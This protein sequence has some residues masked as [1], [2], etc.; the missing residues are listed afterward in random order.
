MNIQELREGAIAKV[1]KSFDGISSEEFDRKLDSDYY[2]VRLLSYSTIKKAIVSPE[3]FLVKINEDFKNSGMTIG[4]FMHV[5]MLEPQ[6]IG[7]LFIILDET[8]FPDECY[9]TGAINKMK[10]EEA[11]AEAIAELKAKGAVNNR[12]SVTK[13]F[14][15]K[16]EKRAKDE[17]KQL[18]TMDIVS[19]CKAMREILLLKFPYMGYDYNKEDS[20]VATEVPM[21]K[22][23][24][25]TLS[26]GEVVNV[27]VR[28]KADWLHYGVFGEVE[29]VLDYKTSFDLGRLK[30]DFS[31]KFHYDL[32]AF[33]YSEVFRAKRYCYVMQET[34]APYNV[35][36]IRGVKGD[37]VW[38]K[39]KEKFIKCIENIKY[40]VVDQLPPLP[41]EIE[42]PED[43]VKI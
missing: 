22:D 27:L 6:N 39:G 2:G 37:K 7:D 32:Q 10:D 3:D 25:V 30:W 19:T 33:I 13:E 41:C 38:S 21:V 4:S 5:L 15:D 1:G 42:N 11:K 20:S 23:L 34:E 8:K 26:T 29:E 28:V 18:V 36:V 17:N 31:S 40:G 16:L 43:F 24:E 12:L 14:R 9:T 35:R